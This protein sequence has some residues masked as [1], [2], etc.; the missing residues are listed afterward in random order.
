MWM[1]FHTAYEQY[2]RANAKSQHALRKLWISLCQKPVHNWNIHIQRMQVFTGTPNVELHV[3][4]LHNTFS[5]FQKA[6]TTISSVS[7]ETVLWQHQCI[8]RA[9]TH[10][11]R[12]DYL[13]HTRIPNMSC[14]CVCFASYILRSFFLLLLLSMLC[15]LWF[16][17]ALAI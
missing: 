1:H 14:L 12:T 7:N 5:I 9:L 4:L 10:T 13:P 3:H 6:T 2:E 16:V 11:K 15:S 8:E 17:N